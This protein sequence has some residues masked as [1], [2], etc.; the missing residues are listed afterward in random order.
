M[1]ASYLKLIYISNIVSPLLQY[2]QSLATAVRCL[3]VV[4]VVVVERM[5]HSLDRKVATQD[6]LDLFQLGNGHYH[7]LHGC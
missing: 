3:V 5:N 1:L 2:D 7:R 4:V 6:V